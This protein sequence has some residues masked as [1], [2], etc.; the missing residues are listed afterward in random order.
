MGAIILKNAT[1]IS[2]FNL[3]EENAEVLKSLSKKFRVRS[4]SESDFGEFKK[5]FD[6]VKYHFCVINQIDES[7]KSGDIEARKFVDNLGISKIYLDPNDLCPEIKNSNQLIRLGKEDLNGNVEE[8]V[9]ENLVNLVDKKITSG[10]KETVHKTM[11]YITPIFFDCDP[12]TFE[13]KKFDPDFFD[14]SNNSNFDCL[15]SIENNFEWL[16]G[17][18]VIKINSDLFSKNILK[19]DKTIDDILKASQEYS[20]QIM[21]IINFN[22]NNSGKKFKIGLPQ[23]YDLTTSRVNLGKLLIPSMILTTNSREIEIS[24]GHI[25]MENGTVP[26]LKVEE[27]SIPSSDV[28]FF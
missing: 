6:Q 4:F 11:E 26:E 18:L 21:G 28:D 10:M 7:N 8:K 20:N 15:V 1:Y 9:L 24:F 5:S 16:V 12:V 3:S 2:G 19:K 14:F 23:S 27:F 22:L 25:E 17:R 13:E